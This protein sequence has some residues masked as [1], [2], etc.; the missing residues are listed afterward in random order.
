MPTS[1]T[2]ACALRA[3]RGLTFGLAVAAR[4]R[5]LPTMTTHC[6]RPFDPAH[7]C[8][9]DA[10]RRRQALTALA[11]PAAPARRIHVGVF[12]DG[13]SNNLTLDHDALPPERRKHSNVA[14][15]LLAWRHNQVEPGLLSYYVP[16]PGTP[17]PQMGEYVGSLAGLAF[18]AM[19]QAR[20]VWALCQVFNAPWHALH[21]MDSN[22][23]ADAEARDIDRANPQRIA[24]RTLFAEIGQRLCAA[25]GAAAAPPLR[26]DLS[27]FG[28]SRGAAQAR[29]FVNW[30]MELCQT[31][32]GR[33]VLCGDIE[34]NP[35]FLGIFDTV[36]S[37]GLSN[38]FENGMFTGHQGWGSERDLE[39]HPAI[40]HCRHLVAGHEARACFPLDSVRIRSTYPPNALE[41]MYPGSHS[42]VGGGY[43]P[44][45]LGVG[46]T[47]H[48]DMSIIPGL[49]MYR[50][51]LEHGVPL[52][53]LDSLPAD[54]RAAW[55]PSPALVE[56]YNG[57]LR[58]CGVEAGPVET[59][60]RGHMARYHAFRFKWRYALKPADLPLPPE[61]IDQPG[62]RAPEAVPFRQRAS[63]KDIEHLDIS[64]R[65]ILANLDRLVDAM[66]PA[67]PPMAAGLAPPPPW[68][69]AAVGGAE[70]L[71]VLHDPRTEGGPWSNPDFDPRVAAAN[72]RRMQQQTGHGTDAANQMR[73]EVAAGIDPEALS[74]GMEALFGNYLHDSVAGFCSWGINEFAYNG[75]GLFKYRTVYKG[76]A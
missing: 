13:T 32:D 39:I 50:A 59:M 60:L 47:V 6:P 10:D 58:D 44:G 2:L 51:A 65:S 28:F 43:A 38:L 36:A 7:P 41:V 75:L 11:P 15:L 68:T 76:D 73:C 20:I 56:A 57:Y 21:G 52:A 49:A 37:V 64:Q 14:K 67:I 72:W 55:D 16:G 35:M 74:P 18:G 8:A 69:L 70:E 54:D 3:R 17:F 53:P 22:L 12:F 66:P 62:R 19:G 26:V 9:V 24:R 1:R 46:A 40:G 45:V 48:D 42:D 23:I 31:R 63:D 27:V 34:I 4:G 29:V 25:L 33:R 71:A 30:L 61:L 5:G